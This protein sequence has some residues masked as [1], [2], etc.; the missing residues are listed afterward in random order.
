ME[1][2]QAQSHIMKDGVAD[3]IGRMP[4]CS[5]QA[6]RVVGRNSMAWMGAR[7]PCWK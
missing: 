4:Y 2:A 6:V 5:M 7:T 1:V 3:L